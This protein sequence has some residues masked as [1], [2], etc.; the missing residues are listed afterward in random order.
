MNNYTNITKDKELIWLEEV[1][2]FTISA[3]VIDNVCNLLT[4]LMILYIWHYIRSKGEG[5]ITILDEF[6]VIWMVYVLMATVYQML[7]F[8]PIY[9]FTETMGYALEIILPSIYY[10][11][12]FIISLAY[13]ALGSV[14]YGLVF[15]SSWLAEVKD[16]I[17]ELR[18]GMVFKITSF[19]TFL[20]VY[21]LN[22]IYRENIT[23]DTFTAAVVISMILMLLMVV[24]I[25]GF[26]I[27]AI[28]I[29]I[30]LRL[31]IDSNNHENY[32]SYLFGFVPMLC[33]CSGFAILTV[34]H[35]IVQAVIICLY[36]STSHAKTWSKS[37]LTA[38]GVLYS[39]FFL[40]LILTNPKLRGHFKKLFTC[41]S[42][43]REDPVVAISRD[44]IELNV[45][46]QNETENHL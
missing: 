17:S 36:K 29:Y 15:P 1:D 25:G 4:T 35:I 33:G 11:M 5:M 46:H 24:M 45:I 14:Q 39:C 3:F 20:I 2:A 42:A 32:E 43:S 26:L 8:S 23:S 13:V 37:T 10:A 6:N 41:N 38:S 28:I 18:L 7:I 40:G 12:V 27:C 19:I 16:D 30:L 31:R 22:L 9:F 34:V 44:Q 21:S